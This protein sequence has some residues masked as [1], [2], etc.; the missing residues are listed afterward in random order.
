L[1]SKNRHVSAV[2]LAAGSGSRMC[3]E[4]TKQ[5]MCLDGEC[6]LSRSVR[7]FEECDAISSIV[8]VTRREEISAVREML[9]G[10]KKLSSTVVGGRCRQ[11]SARLGFLAIPSEADFIAV[12]D[13]ARCLI[14]PEMISKVV[15]SAL[16]YGAATAA[17]PVRDTVKRADTRGFISDTLPREEL[18]LAATPQIFSRDIY[19]RAIA[20]CEN[21]LTDY[22]DDNMM[23]ESIGAEVFLVDVGGENIK[24]TTR[25]DLVLAKFILENRK[26][27]NTE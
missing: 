18:F 25:D 17:F 24:I 4:Q 23:A 10:F 6:V 2:I 14:T 1:S 8:V 9:S 16:K 3:S 21:R 15:N 13:A 27:S 5:M 19:E 11:E 22:T 7:A 26:C 12:H 20:A